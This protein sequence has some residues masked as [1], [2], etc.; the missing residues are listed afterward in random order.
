LYVLALQNMVDPEQVPVELQNMVDRTSSRIKWN[1]IEILKSN[2]IH[3]FYTPLDTET[4][5][6]R[7][8]ESGSL[9]SQFKKGKMT[10][11][12]FEVTRRKRERAWRLFQR[13]P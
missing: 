8:G 13:Q 4:Q 2:T 12:K 11:R 9:H 7:V 1:L 3:L 10:R 5:R 6:S